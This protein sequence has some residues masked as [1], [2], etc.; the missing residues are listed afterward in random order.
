MKIGIY[1]GTF[2]PVHR[3]HIQFACDAISAATLDTVVIVAEKNPY[4]KRPHA[5]WD[6]RQAMIERATQSVEQVDHDYEFANMLAHQHTMNDV[7]RIAT[8]HY[9]TDND[10]W[11]LVGSDVFEHMKAWQDIASTQQY[12]G[13]VV[14]LRDNHSREWLDVK[15][16]ELADRGIEVNTV[17]IDSA[18]PHVSSGQVR[19]AVKGGSCPAT[20]HD[21]VGAYISTH[22]LYQT[23][24]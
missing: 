3:G 20:V 19:T 13:F 16:Q 2:D 14:A 5:S 7:L 23:T 24:A 1:A 4:R 18:H 11:F 22:G 9:G 10:F 21:A 6:H 17:V 12:G 15:M 8:A